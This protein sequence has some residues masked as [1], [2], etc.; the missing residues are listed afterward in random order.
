[1]ASVINC[2]YCFHMIIE[3]VKGVALLLALSLLQSFVRR[4]WRQNEVMG[5]IV[6]GLL[7]GSICVIG[8]KMPIEVVPGVIFDAR[9]V[10]LS[11]SG[12]F[13]GPIV[14]VIAAGIAGGYRA[15]IGGGGGNVGVAVIVSTMSL[16]LAYRYCRDRGWVKIDVFQLLA[17]GFIV[18]AVE[19]LLFTQLP[20]EVVQQVMDNVAIPL[21]LT[22]TPAT[23]FLG[24]LLQDIERRLATENALQ[25]SEE[26]FHAFINYTPSKLHIKDTDGHYI[27]INHK[28]E[29][30]FGVTNEEAKG[31]TAADIFPSEMGQGFST[32]D[33]AVVETGEPIEAEEVFPLDDSVH[34]YLTVKFPIFGTD[35]AVVAVGSNG[36]DIT[37]RKRA[38]MALQNSEERFKGFAKISSDWLWEMDSEL[39]FTYFSPRNKEI[40][41]FKP[42][43]YLGKSRREIC[44]GDIVD[45]HWQ[46]HLRDLDAHREFR[47]FEYDLKIAG[48][49]ILTISIS[50]NPLFDA[51]GIFQGYYGT[52]KD[53][54]ERKLFEDEL[55]L[56]RD[57]LEIKI[58]ERTKELKENE[59][60]FRAVTESAQDAIISADNSG[61]IVQWNQG[62]QKMFGYATT[63]II[64]QSV[65]TL[66]PERYREAHTN[67]LESFMA[68]GKR[69]LVN[70]AVELEAL[71]K[72]GTECSI[73][74]TISDWAIGNDKF[75]T[76]IIRDI[77]E[78]QRVAKELRTSESTLSAFLDSTIDYAA[79]VDN[80]GC[81]LIVN[82]AMTD[83][84]GVSRNELIG[85]P[86]FQTPLSKT[87]KRRH[88]WLT[89]VLNSGQ[90]IRATDEHEGRWYDNSYFPVYDDGGK[91]TRVAIFAREITE[92][93]VAMEQAE[94]S[95]RAKTELLA[96]MSHELRTPLNAIIGF[97]GSIS[98][99]TF[100][101]IGNKK[102]QEYIADIGSSGEHLLELINDIL[103]VSA[104]EAGK[105]ELHEANIVIDNLVKASVRIIS[106]RAN[107]KRIEL[108]TITAEA[109]P[110]F[111]GDE[112]RL[113][114]IL[115]NLLSNA[116]KF[117]PKGGTVTLSVSHED[118]DGHV[119][120]VTDTGIGMSKSE[121]T[122]AMTQFGQVD[123]GHSRKEG[124]TGLGLP[125]TK[126][127]VELHGGTLELISDKD[128]GTTVIVKFPKERVL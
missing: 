127:L 1:M 7:F 17:F 45:E 15:W 70:T 93:K 56:A 37:E 101:P 75:V 53:V 120:T 107:L 59:T 128:N 26:R 94:I 14:G 65:T 84:Y 81:F 16:G 35:G 32:H 12:L 63:E 123:S 96:N 47:D 87:G 72:D 66:I 40:T 5:Q 58:A 11:M 34:T 28:S 61:L 22:F 119:F 50:G 92:M 62:A 21:F 122:K 54:T 108:N 105:F 100:G 9:S 103:D 25:E 41:G 111:Y 51:D 42:E 31:K 73:E 88:K 113:K 46:R 44:Y 112:R 82:K 110:L 80:E 23:A 125:L 85:R 30:L 98:A 74:L 6:S 102:Y 91:V 115:L 13:G 118:G 60:R 20:A 69:R 36:I 114:Q 39:R 55:R 33:R 78:R 116:V 95:N 4:H 27:L 121:L 38:E 104:I 68:G 126:G 64:G 2:C 109:L 106:E 10:I 19:V 124:G 83:Q 71:R 29:E 86:M 77:G 99:E 24:I 49:R 18:H 79:L 48:D 3:L 117:T 43:L 8:M 90:P 67:G 89:D 76:S 52:G 97:T 57:N